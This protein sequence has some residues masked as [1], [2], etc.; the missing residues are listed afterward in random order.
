MPLPEPTY[1]N[2]LTLSM[3]EKRHPLLK[4]FPNMAEALRSP[5]LATGWLSRRL[6]QGG[7]ITK[8]RNC[9]QLTSIGVIDITRESSQSSTQAL[10]WGTTTTNV[11]PK[12]DFSYLLKQV[13]NSMERELRAMGPKSPRH[14]QY[15]AFCQG[16]VEDIR[17]RGGGIIALTNFFVK[18]STYYWP[19]E[20]DPKLFA[21]SI[22]SYSLRLDKQTERLSELFHYLYRGWR[23]DFTHGLLQNHVGYIKKGLKHWPFTEFVLTE[24][25]PAALYV[26]FNMN[27]GWILCSNYLPP[28]ADRISKLLKRDDS[29]AIATFSHLATI[30]KIIMN[31]CMQQYSRWKKTLKG[32][33]P[34]H[35]GIVSVAC[36]FW[37]ALLPAVNEY[38]DRHPNDSVLTDDVNNA[39]A[40]FAR[41]TVWAFCLTSKDSWNVASFNIIQNR[42]VNDGVRVMVTDCCDNWTLN[43]TVEA[44]MR[45]KSGILSIGGY[46]ASDRNKPTVNLEKLWPPTLQEVLETGRP[47]FETGLPRQLP[48]DIQPAATK[49]RRFLTGFAF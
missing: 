5:W 23:N 31:G 42:R 25:L 49:P 9:R 14:M 40:T 19:E 2:S 33:H 39:L 32:F 30:L 36:Q 21:A 16:I 11:F 27:F 41:E 24:F 3:F 15:L 1:L 45:S 29:Q 17:S 10:D 48:V 7:L 6:I 35:R 22:V 20:G 44:A 38:V 8:T 26:G 46:G 47:H 12:R 34:L 37:L 13:L 18:P 28:L 4:P 43:Q